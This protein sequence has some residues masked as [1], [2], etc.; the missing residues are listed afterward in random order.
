MYKEFRKK[1]TFPMAI[2]IVTMLL[3]TY[4]I[5]MATTTIQNA[6]AYESNQAKS[7]INECGNGSISTNIGCQNIDSQIQGDENT[8]AMTG[9]QQFPAPPA[10]ETAT[11]I[12]IKEVKCVEGEECPG[13]PSPSEFTLAVVASGQDAIP[14]GEGSEFEFGEPIPIPP[15]DYQVDGDI[16][17]PNVPGLDFVN[18]APDN[19]CNSG[20]SGGPIE[21]GEERTCIFT[22]NYAPEP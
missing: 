17:A 9:R 11:L 12:V 4:S 8:V 13:L 10:E 16:S 21:A 7:D 19:G 6:R 18:V 1:S 3:A 22:N 20:T 5:S 14:V 15:G 2:M